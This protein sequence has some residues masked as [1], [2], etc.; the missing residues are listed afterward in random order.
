M[1]AVRKSSAQTEPP[2]LQTFRILYKG[3][4]QD[5]VR[6]HSFIYQPKQG[7]IIKFFDAEATEANDL[8]LRAPE[9]ASV[10]AQSRMVEAPA[11]IEVQNQVR[12]LEARMDALE[13]N[14]VDI[15]ASALDVVLK[16][17]GLQ[18]SLE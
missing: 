4:E 11:L 5:H 6:A 10:L 14:L 13:K 3:G 15:V 9:V 16:K 8:L 17:R 18:L 2:V 7:D 12:N 1:G